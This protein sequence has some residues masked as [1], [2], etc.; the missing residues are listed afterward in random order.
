MKNWLGTIAAAAAVC[1]V[2]GCAEADGGG[3]E[4]P[5][6]RGPNWNGVVPPL[7]NGE[8]RGLPVE[9]SEDKNIV[10]KTAIPH[11]GWSTPAIWGNQ[12]WMTT[13][14]PD[15]HEMFAICVD[16]ES[17]EILL[18]KKLFH[19][20]S[21]E[22]LGNDVN[23]YASCSPA[24]EEG[25][26]YLHFGSYGTA[27]LDTQTFET[28]WE[29]RDL[30]CRHYRGPGSSP[31]IFEDFLI[32][33]M[34]GV[35]V[36]YLAALDKKTGETVWKTDR[37][38][39]FRDLGPDGLPIMEGDYR[40]AYVTPIIVE[41]NGEL[42]MII[43]GAR[44]A[45]AYNPRTGEELWKVRNDGF[46]TAARPVYGDGLV[47]TSTG[48]GQTEILAIRV[49][50]RGDIT[51]THVEWKMERAA[52]KM[53]SPLLVDGLLYTVSN[54][55]IATCMDAKTGETI[56]QNRIQGSY[57]ASPIYADGHVYFFNDS[58]IATVVEHGREF[59]RIAE[60]ELDEG[61]MASPAVAGKALFL[62]TRTH[63]Y[64]VEDKG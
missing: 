12:I 23:S 47:Y 22:P 53:A 42:Q 7:A 19:N 64:R 52:P 54:A 8:P 3:G 38:T 40:K 26:A 13:A 62:R 60:N 55:G 14:T 59:K 37:T 44:E 32:L 45:Y 18:N 34:D 17:G 33:T 41:H 4:W 50:G 56:W 35:D 20:E 39:D 11:K 48:S 30:P 43:P 36:Q 29:R 61:F 46:S 51:D 10:W 2:T 28:L 15:G 57:Y 63:L 58:K 6:F 49:D 27:C 25:R 16:R 5:D 1:I 21:P 24:I 31:V 9:W